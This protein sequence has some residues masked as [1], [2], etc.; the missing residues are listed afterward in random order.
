MG[1]VLL[2]NMNKIQMPDGNHESNAIDNFME[3]WVPITFTVFTVIMM[4]V[5]YWG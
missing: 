5:G 4:M 2:S 1:Y 3:I